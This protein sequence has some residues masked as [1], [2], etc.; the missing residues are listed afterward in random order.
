MTGKGDIWNSLYIFTLRSL[1]FQSCSVDLKF[2]SQ[3]KIT[4]MSN[5]RWK[6]DSSPLSRVY[7]VDKARHFPVFHDRA[8]V[9]WKLGGGNYVKGT[10]SRAGYVL[11]VETFYFNQYFLRIRWWFSR[12]FKSF[13]V[14]S[15]IINFFNDYLLVLKMHTETLLWIPVSV[16]GRCSLVPTSHWLQGKCIRISLL[17]AAFVLFYRITGGFL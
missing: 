14:P 13:S 4:L 12:S 5:L 11:K 9:P 6:I 16:T 8:G 15:T 17:Q 7:V 10:V 2:K 1:S 3:K